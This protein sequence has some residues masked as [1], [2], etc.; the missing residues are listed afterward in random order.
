MT[1][2][3]IALMV[4]AVALILFSVL[5]RTRK[6]PGNND[7]GLRVREVRNSQEGDRVRLRIDREWCRALN[8]AEEA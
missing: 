4:L 3:A 2:L 7:F 1:F 6:L 8:P 5:S